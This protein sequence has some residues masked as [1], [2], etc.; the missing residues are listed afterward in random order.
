MGL[1][2]HDNALCC[3]GDTVGAAMCIWLKD[4]GVTKPIETQTS[5]SF[6]QDSGEAIGNR[7]LRWILAAA[8]V[9]AGGSGHGIISS[10]LPL[11]LNHNLGMDAPAVGIIFTIM[12]V[13]S[14]VGPMLTGKL[15]D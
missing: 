13:G 10:F 12:S 1:A 2:H 9:A 7:N 11:Y 6:W 15:T 14:I 4:A 5:S 8:I 3:S